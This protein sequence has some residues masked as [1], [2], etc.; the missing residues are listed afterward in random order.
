MAEAKAAGAPTA[1]A[2][3]HTADAFVRMAESI[4]GAGDAKVELHL[5]VDQAAFERGNAEAGEICEIEGAGPVPVATARNLS[6]RAV[7]HA[8][9]V[10]GTDLTRYA[11]LG[12]TVPAALA[13]ALEERDPACVELGC[14]VRDN[15]EIHH[16]VPV[17]AGG[18]TS[19]E[20]LER[21][22]RWHHYLATHH[23]DRAPPGE[24]R[25]AG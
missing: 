15:L 14:N 18:V 21:R 19:L 13:R 2:E 7:V 3:A 20:N 22:C 1:S 17:A 24:F 10:D 23:P 8:L 5:R 12:R 6:T 4:N 9:V 11:N 25:L 16:K